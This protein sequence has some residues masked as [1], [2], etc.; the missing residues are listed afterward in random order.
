LSSLWP[1]EEQS[2]V[3]RAEEAIACGEHRDAVLLI[4]VLAQRCLEGVNLVVGQ[5][6]IEPVTLMQLLGMRGEG[7]IEFRMLCEQSRGTENRLTE[8]EAKVALLFAT[9]LLL[10]TRKL[11]GR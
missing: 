2:M 8:A 11:L 3:V 9:H 4:D 1:D 7:I 5:P 10:L 6:A